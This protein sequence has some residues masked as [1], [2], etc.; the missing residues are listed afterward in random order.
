[1][2]S[3]QIAFH[4]ACRNALAS[5]SLTAALRWLAISSLFGAIFSISNWAFTIFAQYVVERLGHERLQAE[6]VFAR[7]MVER[8]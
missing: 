1:M 5:S 3:H 8:H 2:R 7:A 4:I 6:I